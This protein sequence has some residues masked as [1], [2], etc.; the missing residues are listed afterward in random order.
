[1]GA[2]PIHEVMTPRNCLPPKDLTAR[3]GTLGMT[4]Q[5]MS[6]WVGDTNIQSIADAFLSVNG[7][8]ELL[9]RQTRERTAMRLALLVRP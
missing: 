9:C 7:H 6:F 1:M 2:N 8:L 3:H 5:C 4:F